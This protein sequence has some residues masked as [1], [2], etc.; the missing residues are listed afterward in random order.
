MGYL[1]DR[2]E[3]MPTG[4]G[5]AVILPDPKSRLSKPKRPPKPVPD[6]E[7]RERG[8]GPGTPHAGQVSADTNLPVRGEMQQA[9]VDFAAISPEELRD[10][11]NG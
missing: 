3:F 5:F 11:P 6:V 10:R 4:K 9:D 8:A 7:E 1:R 2:A